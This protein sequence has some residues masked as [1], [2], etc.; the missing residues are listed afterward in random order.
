[1]F[2]LVLGKY[3]KNFIIFESFVNK[4]QVCN[5]LHAGSVVQSCPTLCDAMDCSPPGPSVHATFQARILEWVAISYCR[6]SSRPR[7]G[8][9]FP[10][11]GRQIFYH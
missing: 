4:L 6:V 8:K 10:C 11:I 7:G 3:V 9:H 1:M 5:T 2:S